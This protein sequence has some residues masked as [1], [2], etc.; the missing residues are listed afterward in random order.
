[1]KKRERQKNSGAFMI[2]VSTSSIQDRS[3]II[4]GGKRRGIGVEGR[5]EG[6]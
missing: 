1:M 3:M 4:N 5:K 2:V 6:S